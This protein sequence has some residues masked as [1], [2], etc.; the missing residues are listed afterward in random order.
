MSLKGFGKTKRPEESLI[1]W[2]AV[3]DIDKEIMAA[4]L[5]PKILAFFE[6]PENL[7]DFEE[8]KKRR[9]R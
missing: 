5:A 2:G 8:W 9:C 6:D 1:D 3:P 7:K 4:H